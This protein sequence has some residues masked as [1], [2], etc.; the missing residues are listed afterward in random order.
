VTPNSS[1]LPVGEETKFGL[2]P[3]PRLNLDMIAVNIARDTNKE[4]T[5]EPN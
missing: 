3:F 5:M 4:T 1:A 2:S